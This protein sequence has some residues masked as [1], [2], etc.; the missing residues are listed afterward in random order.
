MC[1]VLPK[2][3]TVCRLEC[4]SQ[5]SHSSC[6]PV[7]QLW[8]HCYGNRRSS[9]QF[10]S[11][12]WG[13]HLSQV[14]NDRTAKRFWHGRCCFCRR[15]VGTGFYVGIPN[16]TRSY[17]NVVEV[18]ACLRRVNG[19]ILHIYNRKCLWLFFVSYA[20]PQFWADWHKIW[21]VASLNPTGGHVEV[22]SG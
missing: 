10:F 1:Q 11:A 15:F 19:F 3:V 6:Q 8:Y 21:R 20:R 14:H 22:K 7:F 2:Q 12:V 13:H 5:R 4:L 16:V 18:I 9:T 17:K